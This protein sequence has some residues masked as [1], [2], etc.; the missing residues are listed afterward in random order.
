MKRSTSLG[1][2]VMGF[3]CAGAAAL[4]GLRAQDGP[5]AT[6]PPAT[7]IRFSYGGNVAQVPSQF[8]GNLIFLPVRVNRSQP[9]LFQVDTTAAFSSLDPRRAA[10]LGVTNLRVARAEFDRR[11]Y[12][13]P[14]TWLGR[15]ERF[16]STHRPRRTKV[17]SE[18]TFS[19]TRWWELEYGRQ[20][21]RMYDPAAFQFKGAGKSFPLTMP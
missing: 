21:V 4:P 18:T 13:P 12:P 1:I 6:P 3:M 10:D 9:S 14:R 17:R 16:R 11:R 19:R 2:A 8:I 15:Q 5:P 7:M 20:T